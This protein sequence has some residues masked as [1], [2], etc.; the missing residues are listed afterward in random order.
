MQVSL[1]L[2]SE[3]LSQGVLGG[4]G[5]GGGN[6]QGEGLAP[7]PG[8]REKTRATFLKDNGFGAKKLA[9]PNKFWNKTI[10]K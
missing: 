9:E 7:F 8:Q 4:G 5:G 10:S 6:P 2:Q 1:D 3:Y